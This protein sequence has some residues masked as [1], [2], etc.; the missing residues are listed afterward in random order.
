[1]A[2]AGF[3]SMCMMD[4]YFHYLSFKRTRQGTCF[5]ISSLKEEVVIFVDVLGGA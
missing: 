2:N 1:M 5:V 3:P 4:Q